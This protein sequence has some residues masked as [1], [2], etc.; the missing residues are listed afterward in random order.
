MSRKREEQVQP[1]P[2]AAAPPAAVPAPKTDYR[3]R[4][5]GAYGQPPAW[6]PPFLTIYGVEGGESVARAELHRQL[7]EAI[8]GVDANARKDQQTLQ[9]VA[10]GFARFA[11]GALIELPPNCTVE[12]EG[13]TSVPGGGPQVWKVTVA[14]KTMVWR[15]G[16]SW[17]RVRGDVAQLRC[18]GEN[19]QRAKRP[20]LFPVGAA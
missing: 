7:D 6:L 14:G 15:P 3:F 12:A 4:F 13:E 20:K 16:F 5:R 18:V 8:A 11:D 2:V 10:E 1:V 9:S 17:H 19:A